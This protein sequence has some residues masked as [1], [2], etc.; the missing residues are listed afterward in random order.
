MATHS[1]DYGL[2]G[3]S[4]SYLIQRLP[5]KGRSF[6]GT[7]KR[8]HQE[9]D[10]KMMRMYPQGSL[11]FEYVPTV[12]LGFSSSGSRLASLSPS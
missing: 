2:F 6:M 9:Y 11:Y 12:F 3:L 8:E 1:Q 7:R 10:G 4:P 5:M